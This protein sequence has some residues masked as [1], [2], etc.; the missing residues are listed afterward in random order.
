MYLLKT[1]QVTHTCALSVIFA[2]LFGIYCQT[3]INE[4]LLD[5]L[6]EIKSAFTPQTTFYGNFKSPYYY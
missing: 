4:Y 1:R 3:L 2:V 6:D 5:V